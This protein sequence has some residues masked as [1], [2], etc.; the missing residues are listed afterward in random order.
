MR[1]DEGAVSLP[2]WR[3]AAGGIARIRRWL[4]VAPRSSSS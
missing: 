2:G 3:I 4:A 1:T